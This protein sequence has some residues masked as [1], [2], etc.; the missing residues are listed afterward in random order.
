MAAAGALRDES[1]AEFS[2]GPIES[3]DPLEPLGRAGGQ[4]TG[5]S[6]SLGVCLRKQKETRLRSIRYCNVG[7]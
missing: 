6:W 4:V 3:I 5:P 7:V 1:D 2:W